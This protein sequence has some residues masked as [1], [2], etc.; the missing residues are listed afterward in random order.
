MEIKSFKRGLKLPTHKEATEGAAVQIAPRPPRVYIPLSQHIGAPNK[1]VVEVGQ[2]VQRGQLIADAIKPGPMTVPV[3]ASISGIVKKIEVR[4]LSNNN[5]GPCLVIE[6][7]AGAEAGKDDTL[8]M[9]PLDPFTCSKDE[10][11]K[12]IRDAGIVGMGGASF[13]TH[14]KLNPPKP[15]D[16][17]IAN[18]AECEPY[19]TTDAALLESNAA[20]VLLGLAI[21]MHITGV[22][23]GY[24]GMEDNKANLVPKIEEEI[25]NLKAKYPQF[26]GDITVQLCQT[27]Y[28]QGGEKMLIEALTHREVPSAKLPADA[29]CIVDNVGTLCCIGEAFIQGKPLIDRPLTVSGGACQTPKNIVVPLGTLIN[30]LPPDF[31][32]LDME[33]TAKIVFG[34]PMM[35]VAVSRIDIPVQ[36]NTSGILLLTKQ[37]TIAFTEGPCIRCARCISSCPMGL[38]PAQM[39]DALKAGEL[40][41]A[42]NM[43]LMD[44]IECGACSWICPARIRLTQRFR[45][46]KAQYKAKLADDKAKAAA[47][48]AREAAKKEKE[49]VK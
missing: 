31:M 6:A 24:V 1:A 2:Q 23:T 13:P 32:K 49:A 19:L 8:Y 26:Q 44:C 35:G 30:E 45:V 37:E 39:N 40:V 12:R 34:G 16:V 28:P 5:L 10:A 42:N 7:Q 29:G 18:A 14:V 48:A 38:Q 27:R 21:C 11:L 33:H 25:K 17:F 41:E 36:K 43:G 9:P 20:G 47:K 3:H 4:T 46:G 22:K 15:V